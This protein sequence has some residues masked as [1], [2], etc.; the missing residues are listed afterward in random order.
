MERLRLG[1]TDSLSNWS[2]PQQLVYCLAGN[3]LPTRSHASAVREVEGGGY[4]ADVGET[5]NDKRRR[6]T[7]AGRVQSADTCDLVACSGEIEST[8]IHSQ[9]CEDVILAKASDQHSPFS[10]RE[11]HR[12]LTAL[13]RP[14]LK[15]AKVTYELTG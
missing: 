12:R 5:S 4:V 11:C 3:G 10:L 7:C 14:A 13:P 15:Y 2:N 1:E 8:S 6:R 9:S